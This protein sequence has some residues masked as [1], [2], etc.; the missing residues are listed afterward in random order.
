VAHRV[1]R[2]PGHL[3]FSVGHPFAD[4]TLPGAQNYFDTELLEYEW[5]GLGIPVVV[6]FYRRPLGALVNPLLA[7]GF[8]LERIL[9]PTPT[10]EFRQADPKDYEKLSR[11]PG[12]LCVRA[13]KQ[14]NPLAPPAL[15]PTPAARAQ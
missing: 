10:E 8:V 1:L 6:P 9:E 7:A 15:P 14:V 11:Q 2:Q 13:A 3:V 4:F 5:K 12:F